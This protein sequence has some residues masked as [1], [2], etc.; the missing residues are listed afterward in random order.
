MP[1]EINRIF[2]ACSLDGYIADSEG[3][4][5][6]LHE[7]PNPDQIDMGFSDFMAQ[8]DAL[9]MGRRTFETVCGF[10][11]EWPY[12]KPV[13]VWSSRLA[14]IPDDLHDKAFLVRG[15][16]QQ[17]LKQVHELGHFRLYIDGGSVIQSF[18]CEDLIDEMV[19]TTIPVL[20]GAGTP[21]FGKLSRRLDFRC[22]DSEIFLNRIVQNRYERIRE[23]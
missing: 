19:I 8:T 10:D 2:I 16:V 18:L 4:I 1:K 14:R 17:V 11:V 22:T 15:S 7:V 13:F 20:L 23:R 9:V 12:H 6:W 3:G 5:E 21:L